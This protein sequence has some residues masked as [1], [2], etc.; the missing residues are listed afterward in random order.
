MKFIGKFGEHLV[1]Q[2][3]LRNDI[4]AYL[5]IK[6]NQDDYDI[7]AIIDSKHVKRIQVKATELHNE[8][9][10]NPISNVDKNYDYL[11]LVV[12][13][14][15]DRIF[16]LT[17]EEMLLEKGTDKDLYISR[18]E[19]KVSIVRESIVAHEDRWD[20]IKNV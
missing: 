8:G 19:N 12:V 11:A 6:S 13:E 4:E 18:K 14:E 16:I 20:K 1:L 2:E 3:L 9:T 17:K 15:T 7:T 10:N 5:A